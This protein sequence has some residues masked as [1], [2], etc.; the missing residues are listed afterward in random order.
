MSE[1]NNGGDDVGVIGDEL[2][3]EVRETKERANTFDG[4]GGVP[5]LD[6]G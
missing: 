4:G 3:V 2:L 5:V 1:E 6:C